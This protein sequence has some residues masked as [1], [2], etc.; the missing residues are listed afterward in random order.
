MDGPQ[1]Q[2]LWVFS[3]LLGLLVGSFLNVVVFRLPRNCMSVRGPRSRC[4]GCSTRIAWFDNIPVLSW[5]LLRGRC[6]SCRAPISPRYAGVEL[7]TGL[8]FLWAGARALYWSP[9]PGSGPQV[10]RFAV[11]ALFVSVLVAC[12]FI[13]IDFRIL[14]DEITI[15]GT[16]LALGISAAFP[17]LHPEAGSLLLPGTS[18]T[19]RDP[20]LV[21]LAAA[22]VGALAGGGTLYGVAVLGKI[23]FRKRIEALGE[24]EAMGL[25]DVKYMAMI[26]ALLGWRGVLLTLVLGC[27]LG[28]VFGLVRGLLTR[29]LGTVPFGPFLSAG[30]LGMLFLEPWVTR[31]MNAYMDLVQALVS[32]LI[33]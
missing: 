26:G 29:R 18:L 32:R 4:P 19:L 12:T 2:A 30:A 24:T 8:L 6:R 22:A 13:D 16:V 28:A 7:L 20:H 14:P 3:G 31:G 25:G 23:L 9:Q 33:R 17:F 1:R 15:P 11:E 27:L 21:S 10:L 5:I